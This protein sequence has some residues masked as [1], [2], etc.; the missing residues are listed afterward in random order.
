MNKE[1][2]DNER[3]QEN[4]DAREGANRM[5]TI[6]RIGDT[7]VNLNAVERTGQRPMQPIQAETEI[8]E[9]EE[10]ENK[11]NIV[12]NTAL[13]TGSQDI[14][15]DSTRPVNTQVRASVTDFTLRQ[16]PSSENLVTQANEDNAPGEAT[17]GLR[18]LR[19]SQNGVNMNLRQS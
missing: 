6:E 16:N 7:E 8:Q 1:D 12:V 18:S 4:A 13:M 17:T 15:L 5:S 19:S 2:D 10:E 3:S 9:E 11:S 14:N